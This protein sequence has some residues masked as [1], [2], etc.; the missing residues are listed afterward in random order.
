MSI[1]TQTLTHK[2]QVVRLY[3]AAVKAIRDIDISPYAFFL[4][5]FCL[6]QYFSILFRRAQWRYEATLL[7]DRFEKNR[8]INDLRL[9]KALLLAG[10]K[11]LEDNA[12]PL[13]FQCK[14]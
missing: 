9:A 11:E 7:R 4:N 14:I 2:Q 10:Q 13:P 5:T 6:I 1:L 12:H 3:K 8:D